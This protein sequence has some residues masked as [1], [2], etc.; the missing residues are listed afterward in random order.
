MK[1]TRKYS[2]I[3]AVFAVIVFLMAGCRTKSDTVVATLVIPAEDPAVVIINP[4]DMIRI[5]AGT[6][7]M[8]SPNGSGDINGDDAEPG[9]YSNETLH[10][11]TLTGSFYIGRYPVTQAQYKAVMNGENPSFFTGDNLP[12]E[13]VSWFDA[14]VFCNR[15]SM[16]EGFSPA[17]SISGS[18]DPEDWGDVPTSVRHENYVSWIAVTIVP[19]SNGYRLPTEAQWEYSCRAGTITAFNWGSDQISSV[20]ANFDASGN[21]FN[22]SPAGEKRDSTTEVGSFAPNEWGLYDK[23]GNVFE[24]CWDWY[25]ANFYSSQDAGTDPTGPESGTD[26]VVRGGAWS[27]NGRYL[28][29]ACR[30]YT[31][32][33]NRYDCIGFRLVR[34]VVGNE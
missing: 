11:V 14:I 6:F 20:Q 3:I 8:G 7:M 29:S 17:Y 4:A 1:K 18:I 26:R 34:P 23:H 31:F 32:P 5:T 27:H 13:M 12:V 9:R 2:S 19:D 22:D 33:F 15:L 16:L 24:W 10:E 21:L 25:D 30:G 28:R